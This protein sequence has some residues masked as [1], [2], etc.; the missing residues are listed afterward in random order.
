MNLN[1]EVWILSSNSLPRIIHTNSSSIEGPEEMRPLG[2]EKMN[3]HPTH[4]G[5]SV[6]ISLIPN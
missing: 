3:V 6:T 2:K 1:C 5:T 4:T